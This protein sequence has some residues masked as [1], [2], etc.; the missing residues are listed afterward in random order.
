MNLLGPL[1]GANSTYG[2]DVP[3]SETASQLL[4][5]FSAPAFHF[6]RFCLGSLITCPNGWA[7]VSFGAGTGGHRVATG[8]LLIETGGLS[9]QGIIGQL[10]PVPLPATLWMLAPALGGLG[11]LRRRPA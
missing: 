6:N 1:S 4:F 3:L 11:F 7:Y 2:G 9:G 10:A 5:D 8:Q